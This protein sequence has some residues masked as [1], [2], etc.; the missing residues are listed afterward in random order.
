MKCPGDRATLLSESQYLF[1]N[2]SHTRSHVVPTLFRPTKV[3]QLVAIVEEAENAAGVV[4]AIGS[5]WTFPDAA[6]S[7]EVTVAINTDSLKTIL[8]GTDETSM[9]QLI[10]FALNA[11][12]LLKKKYFVHVEAGIKIHALNCELDSRGLA[13]DTLGG[14]NGQSLAGAISTGTHGSDV[15]KP[16]LADT[17]RAI[18]LVGPGGQEWW[19]E[20]SG[21]R[22]ITERTRM[23]QAQQTNLFCS[24]LRL[25]YN[26]ALFNAALVSVGR[27][28]V[29]YSYV[30]EVVDAFKLKMA[31]E[32]KL[33]SEAATFIRTNIRDAVPYTGA[34][35][36]EIVVNPYGNG[37][38]SGSLI[39]GSPFFME[40]RDCTITTKVPTTEASSPESVPGPEMSGLF[41]NRVPINAV[42]DIIAFEVLPALT[43]TAT[44]TAVAGLAPLLLLPDAAFTYTTL[45]TLAI[46]AATATFVIIEGLVLTVRNA[47]GADLAQKLISLINTMVSSGHNELV[48][49]VPKLT[50]LALA[51]ERSPAN[52]PVVRESFRILTGQKACP[53]WDPHPEFE[54]EVDGLEMALD[55]SPG[56]EKLFGFVDDVFLL[57][58]EY[59]RAKTPMLVGFTLRFTK[60]TEAL[61]GMQQF[62][63]T[64][65]AEFFMLRGLNG[66]A[67][68]LQRLFAIAK[69]HDALPHW[70]LIHEISTGEVTR[71]YGARLRQWR[72]ALGLLIDKGQ[73]KENTFGT[74]YSAARGL[75]PLR[76]SGLVFWDNSNQ[77]LQSWDPGQYLV[78]HHPA[79]AKELFLYNFSD[80]AVQVTEVRIKTSSDAPGAPVFKVKYPGQLLVNVLGIAY[81]EID[82]A[83]AAAGPL[84]GSVEVDC[85][86]PVE[87]K[88]SIPLSTSVKPLGK[89]AELSLAPDSLDFGT[90]VVGATAPKFLDVTNVGSRDAVIDNV[91]LTLEQP[92][93]QFH[94]PFYGL[95]GVNG[96]PLTPGESHRLYVSYAPTIKGAAQA[97]LVINMRSGTDAGVEY[98]QHVVAPFVGLSHMPVIS[99]AA[100]PRRPPIRGPLGERVFPREL[101]LK[102]LDFGLAAPNQSVAASFWIRNVGDAP[103]KVHGV[104]TYPFLG[105]GGFGVPDTSIFPATVPAGGELEVRC[106]FLAGPIPGQPVSNQLVV[107]SD[108]PLRPSVVLRVKGSIAGPHLAEPNELLNLGVVS[109]GASATLTF[110]SDGTSPVTLR[111]V[112][113]TSGAGF[114]VSGAPATMPADLLPGTELVLTVTFTSTQPGRHFDHLALTHDGKVGDSS[115]IRLEAQL[116]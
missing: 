59:L 34:R 45:S 99:L 41:S 6:I 4:K 30:V 94:I 74:S 108:D 3:T 26:D 97:T 22:A 105:F 40:E 54:R 9:A 66:E 23:E 95:L 109:P 89:H 104:G 91:A 57:V 7:A 82:Y 25:E 15:D 27:M 14:S 61:I 35:F 5:G 11:T 36:V 18:H 87:P 68:F 88:L 17:V 24:G 33:W 21:T 28:G 10:P 107:G 100:G 101:E 32:K 111:K 48:Q 1:Q 49:M 96:K 113:L 42:L 102:Q 83:G 114:A 78:E 50:A 103:L 63:R 19:I 67:A 81:V 65:H 52:P 46:T 12:S 55:C 79:A 110:R 90:R 73:G 53:L 70:G 112:S 38:S 80:R 39:P 8:S 75:V 85:D 116:A 115:D 71:L 69:K 84:T 86:D 56:S 51:G 93:G 58:D 43:A 77:V 64:C 13:M 37:M 31:V 44:A 47:T 72:R 98:R 92:A 20:R 2:Y 106:N 16:P 62:S 60:G 29:V 76:K